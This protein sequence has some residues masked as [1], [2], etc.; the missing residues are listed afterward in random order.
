MWKSSFV[1][2]KSRRRC[3]W[4][5]SDIS[6]LIS[7]ERH[8]L[9][10]LTASHFVMEG[11]ILREA[12]EVIQQLH[13]LL[14]WTNPSHLGNVMILR[15]CCFSV[16][17]FGNFVSFESVVTLVIF[18]SQWRAIIKS[19]YFVFLTPSVWNN[20]K[21]YCKGSLI[22]MPCYRPKPNLQKSWEFYTDAAPRPDYHDNILLQLNTTF[23]AQTFGDTFLKS[24]KHPFRNTR[25]SP[26]K[27]SYTLFPICSS[28]GI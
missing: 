27:P 22:T 10:F 9:F 26:L 28:L 2:V 23:F 12:E 15:R 16:W 20:N 24:F 3:I 18:F 21:K 25:Q 4:R 13:F 14:L 17:L 7:F 8:H 19:H 1:K 5:G 11:V 6:I